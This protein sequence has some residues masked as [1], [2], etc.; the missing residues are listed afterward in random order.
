M[1][2]SCR[3]GGARRGAQRGWGGRGRVA[4]L[5]RRPRRP[6]DGTGRSAVQLGAGRGGGYSRGHGR[7]NSREGGGGAPGKA[8]EATV[9]G[10]VG[11]RAG[12]LKW[13]AVRALLRRKHLRRRA[14]RHPPPPR[15]LRAHASRGRAQ[16]VRSQRTCAGSWGR[17]CRRRGVPGLTSPVSASI[18]AGDCRN[19][20]KPSPGSSGSTATPTWKQGGGVTGGG[21]ECR[22]EQ[23]ASPADKGHGPGTRADARRAREGGEART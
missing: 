21:G 14:P 4:C 7:E 20:A 19:L 17:A 10:T 8:G 22:C 23:K 5:V 1:C 16:N 2:R 9:G 12:D 3:A 6:L 18:H 13:V 15:R 11:T